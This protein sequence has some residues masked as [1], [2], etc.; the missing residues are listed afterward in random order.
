MTTVSFNAQTIAA[1]PVLALLRSGIPL[2]LL[3]DLL[4]PRGPDSAEIARR[5]AGRAWFRGAI[6]ARP[7]GVREAGHR[8]DERG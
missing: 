8:Y 1:P 7:I 3:V 4:D 5:E 2:T 6:G